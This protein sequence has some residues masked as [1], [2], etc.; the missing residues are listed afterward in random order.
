MKYATII[1]IARELG[2]SKSTVSR[3]L[4][5][6]EGNVNKETRQKILAMADKLG[7]KRNEL[8]V[9]L[10]KQNTR[11]IGIIVPE[12]IT[13][14]YM[15]F[16]THAQQRLN[17]QGYRVTLA[18][19]HEDPEV[20]RMNL[21][22]FED[23]RVEGILISACHNQKN[24]AI[25]QH[26]IDRG[27]PLVFFDRTIDNLPV[28]KVKIDD[29]LKAFFMVEHLIRSGREKIIHLA[30]PTYIQNAIERKKGY[31][32][33]L[34][35]FHLPYHPEQVIDAGVDFADGEKAI[36]QLIQK[37]IPFDALFCFTEMSALGA[38]SCLQKHQYS[39]P[40]DVS[41]SC[42]SGTTLCVL[43]HPSLTAVEQPVEQMAAI[44][45]HLIIEKVNNPAIP[46]ET[47]ILDA[48]MV[49]R[50]STL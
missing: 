27:I 16:I 9:N 8:A 46:N 14:F 34:E 35:K 19:S 39:I 40:S 44:A 22:M 50:E 42:I 33:A 1:D 30:G 21:Q 4:Q 6:D 18:Q 49:I 26:L 25:Y 38:K 3:A 48:Q 31:R 20:E 37:G 41:I 5:G 12:M 47:V 7:Y 24:L 15:N 23:Y 45:S 43:V 29:Y 17:D 36:E 11:S 2:I 32:D 28:S 13:P 10:R